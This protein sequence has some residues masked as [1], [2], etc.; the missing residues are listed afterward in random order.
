MF[1]SEDDPHHPARRPQA[2][3]EIIPPDRPGGPRLD[4]GP[5]LRV[6]S[7][8][9]VVTPEPFSGLLAL[10]AFGAVALASAVALLGLFLLAVPILGAVLAG[11]ILAALLRGPRRL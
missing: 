7:H 9:F 11:F 10:F 8:R 3:P 2:E 6:T 1:H 4:G 5:R